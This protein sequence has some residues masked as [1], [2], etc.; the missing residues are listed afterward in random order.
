MLLGIPECEKFRELRVIDK[1][2]PGE[3]YTTQYNPL[4]QTTKATGSV[5]SYKIWP[6]NK[7]GIFHSSW[8][9]TWWHILYRQTQQVCNILKLIVNVASPPAA[10]HSHMQHNDWGRLSQGFRHGTSS[11]WRQ[12]RHRWV[13]WLHR[14]G[15]ARLCTLKSGSHRRSSKSYRCRAQR[16]HEKYHLQTL[17]A[18]TYMYVTQYSTESRTEG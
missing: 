8:N 10:G 11:W 2:M 17:S 12:C 15:R 6:L 14:C 3:K 18:N 9:H 7:V 5:T 1:K 13:I 16:S 4:T